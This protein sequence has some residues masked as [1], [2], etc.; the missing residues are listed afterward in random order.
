MSEKNNE[1]DFILKK[2]KQEEYILWKSKNIE[3]ILDP[4]TEIT[5]NNF[6][7][8]ESQM[9]RAMYEEIKRLEKLL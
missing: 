1:C 6:D 7:T 8:W 5:D 4:P 2:E 3:I 9:I